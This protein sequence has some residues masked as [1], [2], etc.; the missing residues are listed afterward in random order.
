MVAAAV[1]FAVLAVAHGGFS[2]VGAPIT[3]FTRA[4]INIGSIGFAALLYL[5]ATPWF[6][7]SRYDPLRALWRALLMAIGLLMVMVVLRMF[8]GEGHMNPRTSLS[9][10]LATAISA[11][12]LTFME[13]FFA[14]VV[15]HSLRPLVFFRRKRRTLQ[16]WRVML[17]LMG[18]AALSTA[19]V[20]P[21]VGSSIL[22]TL[23]RIASIIPM[24][25]CA[26]RLGWIVPLTFRHKL[27]TMLFSTG[28]AGL[29]GIVLV[30]H[31]S[32]LASA[33]G[34]F[35]DT[36][37]P[38]LYLF[39]RS[40]GELV[41]FGLV[42]GLLYTITAVLSLLFH[43]PTTQ[44]FAQQTGEIRAFKALAELSSEVLDRGQLVETISGATL[45]CWDCDHNILLRRCGL[46]R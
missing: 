33:A 9:G 2:L 17:V 23:L 29:I 24:V 8:V 46:A 44:A 43:L 6:E 41:V 13:T 30:Q 3:T 42:F 21:T 25:Y 10:D 28:L 31:F 35:A 4:L 38:Y 26:F 11:I 12:V 1:L 15:L 27:L 37:I 7:R 5:A 20:L 36:R 16:I 19:F 18:I 45:N 32:G 34:A 40:L 14:V 39:S 22:T